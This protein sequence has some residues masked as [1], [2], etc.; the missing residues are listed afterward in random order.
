[1]KQG[2]VLNGYT[3]VTK[4][5]N[6]GGGKCMWAF[7]TR[8]GK[9]YFIKQ[10]LEPKWP[11]DSAPGS[12]ASKQRRRQDCLAFEKRH[13]HVMER[14]KSDTVGAGNIVTAES[15]FREG[16]TYYKVT[17]RINVSNLKGLD[18]LT[19]RQKAVVLRT[20]VLSLQQLHNIGVVHGDLKPDNV[21][22]QKRLDRDLY[23]AKLIDFD[24]SYLTGQPPVRDMVAGDSLYFAP[25]W[26][27]YIRDEDGADGKLLT[28]ATDMFALGVIL[29]EYLA[30]K[31]PGFPERYS[32]AGDAVKAGHRLTLSPL[33]HPEMAR[34][35]LQL[36]QVKPTARPAT[37]QV[38]ESLDDD[39][40]LV[41]M[42]TDR[43]AVRFIA[44][45]SRG[46]G[47][48]VVEAAP[49]AD[50]TGRT[51][52]LKISLGPGA[53]GSPA[54]DLPAAADGAGAGSAAASTPEGAADGASRTSRVRINLGTRATA[55]KRDE[56]PARE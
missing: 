53:G 8:A 30:G 41:S 43:R 34:L 45:V 20:L 55:P 13:Q 42:A 4:P 5:T 33:L 39:S 1:M 3:V 37:Q 47:A 7:A 56:P 14:L 23:T 19:P 15:F 44:G 28:T 50:G 46:T 54:R 51:S 27:S 12:A 9:D 6:A 25:E 49:A 36:I 31:R 2:D 17:K 24:D 35:I 38:I 48:P 26:L 29:H 16:A 18:T 32:S 10:F 22:V 40:V 21:L 11:T 52:R